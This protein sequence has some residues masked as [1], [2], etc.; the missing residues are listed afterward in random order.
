MS[1]VLVD[2][3]VERRGFWSEVYPA[4][5]LSLLV[6]GAAHFA[7]AAARA[8]SG[9]GSMLLTLG[10]LALGAAAMSLSAVPTARRPQY[11]RFSLLGKIAFVLAGLWFA[12]VTAALFIVAA[13]FAPEQGWP[14]TAGA[15][16]GLF[17]F[18]S[19][20]EAPPGT[21]TR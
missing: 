20:I 15:C 17:F 16:A 7:W 5:V 9:G 2:G 3:G 4:V 14:Y 1:T 21:E 11:A 8:F 10:G 18:K 13:W 6:A 12:S 19:L